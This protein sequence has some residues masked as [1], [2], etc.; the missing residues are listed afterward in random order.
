MPARETQFFRPPAGTGGRKEGRRLVP[1]LRIE[2]TSRLRIGFAGHGNGD[3][4]PGTVVGFSRVE[5][6]EEWPVYG[7][8]PGAA[9]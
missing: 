8:S 2:R 9:H 5:L 7:Q 3:T 4:R 6:S 1:W